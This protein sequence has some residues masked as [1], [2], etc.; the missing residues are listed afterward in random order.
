MVAFAAMT[1]GRSSAQAVLHG[2]ARGMWTRW[3][4]C[5]RAKVLASNGDTAWRAAVRAKA[6]R[7]LKRHA[8]AAL[9]H[10]NLMWTKPWIFV[11]MCRP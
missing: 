4:A 3:A 7:R 1:R 11:V 6:L 8:A 2:G 5:A 10:S 9:P